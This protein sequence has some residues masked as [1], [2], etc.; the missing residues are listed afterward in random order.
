MRYR[1]RAIIFGTAATVAAAAGCQTTDQQSRS[2]PQTPPP[3]AVTP[4]ASTSAKVVPAAAVVPAG[5]PA[6]GVAPATVLP[7][8]GATPVG[9]LTIGDLE[10]LALA[11]NPTLVQAATFIDAA[12]GKALQ[13]GLQYNPTAGITGEN[14]GT[15]GRAGEWTFFSLQQQIVTGGKLRLSRQKYEQEAE[16]AE[17][18]AQAQRL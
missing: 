6:S 7:T 14:I 10:R 3:T 18:Q 17:I 13:A 4:I 15:A 16:L 9:P 1:V 8:A 2:R 5:E 12:H 11:N